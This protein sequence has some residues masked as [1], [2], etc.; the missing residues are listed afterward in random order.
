MIKFIDQATISLKAG[1]GGH[2][3]IAFL[4]EKFRAQGG[5][6]GGDGGKGGSII[7]KVDKQLT[8]LQD[9]SYNRHYKA[10]RGQHG[11]G[12]N[13]HGKSGKNLVLK[14]PP[15]LIIFTLFSSHRFF[16]LQSLCVNIMLQ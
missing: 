9:V 3:C 15:E 16:Q 5:P 11:L 14:V 1:D 2:G 7:L 4:R 8:T 6:C 12:K 10:Q 13:M